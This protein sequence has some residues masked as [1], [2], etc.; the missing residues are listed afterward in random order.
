MTDSLRVFNDNVTRISDLHSRSLNNM[1][2]AANQRNAAQ[3]EGLVDDTSA[4]SSQLKNRITKLAKQGAPG[5]EGRTRAEQVNTRAICF[6]ERN[7]VPDG[8]SCYGDLDSAHQ[9]KIHE[10]HPELPGR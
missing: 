7:G 10:L 9:G 8:S 6:V 3:L 2:D 5:Q 1:D 4:L